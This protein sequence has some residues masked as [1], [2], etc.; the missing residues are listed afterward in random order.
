ML[1][2]GTGR[3][4]AKIAVVALALVAAWAPI[5]PS[6]VEDWFSTGIY[7][8]IQRTVT[9]FSNFAPLA[10]LDAL[11]VAAV[12]VVAVA[13]TRAVRAVRRT[14]RARP[15]WTALG[16]LSVAAAVTYLAF[17]FLWG[18]NYRRVPMEQRLLVPPGSPPP[19]AVVQLGLTAAAQLNEL[20]DE[21]HGSG[22]QQEPRD[23]APLLRAFRD[24]QRAL[25][26]A[27][28]AEPGRLKRSMLGPY[29]R[30]TSVD[31]MI[32]PFGLEVLVNPDLL[33]FERPFVAA[34]EWAHLAGYADESE[35]SFVGWLTCLRADAP[36]RYSGWLALYWQVSGEVAQRERARI[37]ETLA[38]GPRRDIDAVV[39][40]IRR[41]EKPWL[42]DAGWRVYDRYLK[43]NR[44]EEGVRSYGTGLT[45]I[46]GA[47]FGDGWIPIRR[48]APSRDRPPGS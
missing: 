48:D 3:T 14:G 7:P 11:S 9:P 6:V 25:S 35:A 23:S 40:R 46:L 2:K 34:H 42:R 10:L 22:W 44:V 38:A 19:E 41:S 21:A 29:F 33:P 20:H 27:P 43:A 16:R 31:G 8:A 1:S 12:I 28:P 47:R 30:W 39:A 26:D 4:I 15:V 45:L 24:I 37:A 5:G 32:N 36:A 18:L 13:L 17:L